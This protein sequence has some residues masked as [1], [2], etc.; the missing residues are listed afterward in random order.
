MHDEGVA[1]VLLVSLQDEA[2]RLKS[3]LAAKTEQ[4]NIQNT[5]YSG[6]DGKGFLQ[7]TAARSLPCPTVIQHSY[8]RLCFPMQSK[9]FLH[10]KFTLFLELK[11]FLLMNGHRLI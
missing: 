6:P 2:H 1:I 3:E 7:C 10:L 9:F 5:R 4:L 8:P 11:V